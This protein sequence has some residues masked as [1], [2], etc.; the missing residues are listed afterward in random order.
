LAEKSVII[1]GAGLAGLSA[2]CYAQM[3]G[4]RSVIFEHHSKAGGVA[5]SWRRGE[6]LVD[7]GI[8]FVMGHRPGQPIHDLYQELGILAGNTFRDM[9]TYARFVDE[10]S[11]KALD[12]TKDLARLEGDLK[13]MFPREAR[14]IEKLVRGAEGMRA[15]DPMLSM[16]PKVP[17]ELLGPAGRIRLFWNM[18]ATMRY[19]LGAYARPMTENPLQAKDPGF[20]RILENLFLPEAPLW[21]VLMVLALLANGQLAFIEGGCPDF[22]GAVE[23][24]YAGLAGRLVCNARVKR[25]LVERERVAGVELAD[26]S[27]HRADH[28]ISAADGH[29]TV[30]DLLGGCYA[31][32]RTYRRFKDWRLIRPLVMVSFGVARSFPDSV[33][34]SIIFLREPIVIGEERTLGLSLRLF[35]YSARFAPLGKTVVQVLLESDWDYWSELRRGRPKYDA[36][37]NRIAGDVLSRLDVLFPG[38]ASQVEMTDVATP[39]TFWRY[40]LNHR[41]AYMGWLPT[42]A[43]IMTTIPKTLPGLKDFYMAGQWVQPGGGVP[44]CLYSGRQAVQIMCYDD[45]RPFVTSGREA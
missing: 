5:A 36:E 15:A 28:V 8:H 7:G 16:N 22:V 41:G 6:Y 19:F 29:S 43:Q 3:N 40:T 37:K 25:I 17:P 31:D 18:R 13:T 42:S 12:V 20:R 38:I 30:F 24:R 4:Y 14:A 10:M 9:P 45:K 44:P 27:Q 1:I 11:G 2:G 32:D 33:P 23:Q 26:G 39:Y 34:L 21:F 35:N